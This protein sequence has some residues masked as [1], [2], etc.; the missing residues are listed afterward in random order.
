MTTVPI[1][2]HREPT[3]ASD[4]TMRYG[5]YHMVHTWTLTL[6]DMA[7]RNSFEANTV[8]TYEP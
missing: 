2:F 5:P 1:L 4:L 7:V 3:F 6:Y 8:A